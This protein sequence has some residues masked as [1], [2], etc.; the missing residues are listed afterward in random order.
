MLPR[1]PQGFNIILKRLVIIR[2][3][4][5]ANP[6]TIV[7][8]MI[9]ITALCYLFWKCAGKYSDVLEIIKKENLD[10]NN[11]QYHKFFFV[12]KGERSTTCHVMYPSIPWE[13]LSSDLNLIMNEL[14]LCD[15]SHYPLGETVNWTHF[16][17]E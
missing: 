13:C 17:N 7:T 16:N 5:L 6:H 4:L 2:S 1:I 11:Y 10:I 9:I 15:V 3:R 12:V 14:S 8:S